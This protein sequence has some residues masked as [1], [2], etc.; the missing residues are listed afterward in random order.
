MFDDIYS[1]LGGY[2]ELE[3][4]R[5]AGRKLAA[6]IRREVTAR[7][8]LATTVSSSRG[9]LWSLL[10]VLCEKTYYNHFCLRDIRSFQIPK[11]YFGD[12][13]ASILNAAVFAV[14][15]KNILP[16]FPGSLGAI[17][18]FFGIPSYRMMPG[19]RVP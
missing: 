2:D 5:E 12:G 14:L 8:I 4:I 13:E 7:P 17:I 16:C 18:G 15:L 10:I 11:D 1:L 6:R 9:R 19:I 3:V